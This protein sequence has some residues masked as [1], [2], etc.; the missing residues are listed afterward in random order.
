MLQAHVESELDDLVLVLLTHSLQDKKLSFKFSISALTLL[1]LG[2][3]GFCNFLF[4]FSAVQEK[5][6]TDSVPQAQYSLRVEDGGAWG[7][8]GRFPGM[9]DVIGALQV[10]RSFCVSCGHVSL[11][12]WIAE[13]QNATFQCLKK[14][15]M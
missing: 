4:C 11:K 6:E 14:V 7:D 9:N 15:C 12:W 5:L 8:E 13:C 1:Q 2:A 3:C 10:R